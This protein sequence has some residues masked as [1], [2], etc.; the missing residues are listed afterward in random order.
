MFVSPSAR[1]AARAAIEIVDATSK[2]DLPAARGGLALGPVLARGGDY[3]GL[4][5]NLASRLVDGAEAGAVVVDEHVKDA[6]GN[7]F[8]LEAMGSLR[9]RGIGTVS[10]WTVDS[11]PRR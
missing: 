10:A 1:E 6:V 4:P 9:L 11:A 7:G 8:V 3:F 2:R 5:V